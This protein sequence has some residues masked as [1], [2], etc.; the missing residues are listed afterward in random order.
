MLATNELKYVLFD[1]DDTLAITRNVIVHSV[2]K[3]LAKYGLPKWEISRLKRD[4]NL[5]F[6]DNFPNVFGTDLAK[7]AY[8]DY[9]VEYEK[10]VAHFIQKPK[11]SDEVLKKLKDNGIK[12]MIMTNKDRKLFEPE[13]SELYSPDLFEKIVCGH[14]AKK[15]K[16]FPEHGWKALEGFLNPEEISPQKVW[17][18][19]D[20][21]QDLD[22]AVNMNALPILIG[23]PIWGE[24]I[25]ENNVLK[26]DSFVTFFD[27]ISFD[28]V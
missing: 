18:V 3:V 25:S 12:L 27:F 5:S 11:G 13:F 14:E 16:P 23:K 1:W 24:I 9:K 10:N 22:C 2:E 19:G 15:D 28:F 7:Q 26:F 4:E 20:S 17:V 8:E 21:R 6:R